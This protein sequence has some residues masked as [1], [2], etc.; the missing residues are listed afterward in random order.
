MID[1]AYLLVGRIAR[2]HGKKGK[3]MVISMT[4]FPHRFEPGNRL[5]A[6]IDESELIEVE[7]IDS[8]IHKGNYLLTRDEP[9]TGG[10]EE[11]DKIDTATM[12]GWSR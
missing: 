11:H 2:V 6:G 12:G 5:L 9:A 8:T 3:V 7:I 10:N 4:D 1:P